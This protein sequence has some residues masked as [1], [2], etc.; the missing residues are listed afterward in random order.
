[1][2]KKIG[3]KS[4]DSAKKKGSELRKQMGATWKE[5]SLYIRAR[6]KFCVCCGSPFNLQ[7][8][9]LIKRGRGTTLFDETN[10]NAQ[11]NSCNVRHN[12]YPEFY[13]NWWLAKYGQ[14]AYDQL[15]AKSWELKTD[16]TVAELKELEERYKTLKGEL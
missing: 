12:N 1:M 14:E 15:V 7:A 8:G 6:D 16:W 5:F 2:T 11:C 13:T 9:H 3:Q 10:V 4:V